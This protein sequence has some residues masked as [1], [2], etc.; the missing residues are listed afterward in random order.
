MFEIPDDD[1]NFWENL[2]MEDITNTT[3]GKVCGSVTNSTTSGQGQKRQL[4]CDSNILHPE[5]YSTSSKRLRINTFIK[6]DNHLKS[7]S[8]QNLSQTNLHNAESSTDN[9]GLHHGAKETCRTDCNSNNTFGREENLNV[10]NKVLN[11]NA[12]PETSIITQRAESGQGVTIVGNDRLTSSDT[13]S[14]HVSQQ[15]VSGPG[16]ASIRND[17]SMSSTTISN[18]VS[19]HEVEPGRNRRNETTPKQRHKRKFPGPAGLL[20]KLSPGQSI[21]NVIITGIAR[22]NPTESKDDGVILSSQS[23]D[24]LFSDQPWC[25]LVDDLQQESQD[26]L[27]KYSILSSLQKAAKKMLPEGKVALMFA[28]LE[29]VDIQGL[30]ASVTLKDRTGKISGTVHRD[31]VKEFA[32]DLQPGVALVLKQVSVVSPTCRTHYLNITSKNIV[33]LYPHRATTLP[34]KV[35]EYRACLKDIIQSANMMALQQP[36]TPNL[37][38]VSPENKTVPRMQGSGCSTPQWSSGHATP[39]GTTPFRTPLHGPP[40]RQ[41]TP[42]RQSYASLVSVSHGVGAVKGRPCVT[43][44]SNSAGC[45]NNPVTPTRKFSFKNVNKSVTDS[46]GLGASPQLS[47]TKSA[48]SDTSQRNSTHAGS[49]FPNCKT[50]GSGN[51]ASCSTMMSSGTAN[52]IH[53]PGSGVGSVTSKT[54]TAQNSSVRGKKSNGSNGV[55]SLGAVGNPVKVDGSDL[56]GEDLSDELLSQLSEEM[57]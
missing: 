51:R 43:A 21:A 5:S 10:K 54:V 57:F 6:N 19:P 36:S 37:H 31:V 45:P 39:G 33:H 8:N 13:V 32:A 49:V 40:M 14:N 41:T 46:P 52:N 50:S 29:S 3:T 25:S 2:P 11:R 28:V 17:I 4:E 24:D 56:W 53:D 7:R 15:G 38:R 34:D 26:V 47:R 20:P 30:D 23:S 44:N 42:S 22:Q 35:C 9:R 18:H 55:T 1:D 48:V 16:V 12:V 27:T